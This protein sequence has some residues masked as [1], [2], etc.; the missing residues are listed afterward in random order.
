MNIKMKQTHLGSVYWEMHYS[1]TDPAS[2]FMEIWN[3]CWATFGHPGT[4]P[5]TGVKSEWD[6]HGGWLY[7]YD[8]KYVTMFVL[9][10]S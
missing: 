1:L 9:R 5:D 10:W 7:F 4:D 8:E 6:Y 3:W 2:K